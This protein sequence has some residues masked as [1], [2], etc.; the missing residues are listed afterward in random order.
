MKWTIFRPTC[1]AE[2]LLPDFIGKGFASMWKGIGDKPLPV[3][4]TLDI[5]ACGTLAFRD[6]DKYQGRAVSLAGDGLTFAEAKMIFREEMGRDMPETYSFLGSA[7]K[8]VFKEQ[9]GLMFDWVA[10]EGMKADV[11]A[12][13]LKERSGFSD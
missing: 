9:L 11:P 4:S 3:I 7:L 13:R 10:R 12:L 5:V 6:L 2:M 8:V 1:F